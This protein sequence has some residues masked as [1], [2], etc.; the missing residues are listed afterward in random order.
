MVA[1]TDDKA[2]LAIR[3]RIRE[4]GLSQPKVSKL[5]GRSPAWLATQVLP[6]PENAVRYLA[7][8][9][10]DTLQKL[11]RALRWTWEEFSEATGITLSGPFLEHQSFPRGVRMAPV[12]GEAAA[13]RPYEYPIP[14]DLY[15][16]STVIF[17]VSGDSMDDGS[18]D[19]IREGDMVLVDRSLTTLRNGGLYVLEIIGDGYTLK[20]ARKLNGE[21]V[22]IPWN[23]A[24]PVLRPEEVRVVGEVY[25]VNRFRRVRR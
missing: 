1:T 21:W 15:R 9:D 17:F 2:A 24:H 7:A 8:K 18:E 13:G 20:E 10:P 22:F 11:L 14:T 19:A 23:P 25:A 5:A 6:D 4:L 3:K 12:L 16:P